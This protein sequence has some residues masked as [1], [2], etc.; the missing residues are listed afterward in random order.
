[1]IT[2][3][4]LPVR[5]QPERNIDIKVSCPSDANL[6]TSDGIPSL[7]TA[8]L[9]FSPLS[10]CRNSCTLI[11]IMAWNSPQCIHDILVVSGAK[12]IWYRTEMIFPLEVFPTVSGKDFFLGLSALIS[13]QKSLHSPFEI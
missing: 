3:C 6:L 8:L 7:P 9:F 13:F 2:T 4:S 12:R 5:I 1:M 11:I 10:I